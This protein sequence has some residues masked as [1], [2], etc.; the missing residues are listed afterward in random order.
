MIGWKVK[1][2]SLIMLRAET[3]IFSVA[4]ESALGDHPSKLFK[5]R[6]LLQLVK[7]LGHESDY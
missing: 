5:Y 3:F 6:F 1:N 2:G 4:S 7:W